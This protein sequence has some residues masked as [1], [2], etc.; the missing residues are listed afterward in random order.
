MPYF[1]KGLEISQKINL[2]YFPLSRFEIIVLE[3]SKE[4][5]TKIVNFMTPGGGVLVLRCGHISDIVKMNYFCENLLFSLTQIRQFEGIVM[6]SK[7]GS[8]KIVNFMTPRAGIL[9]LGC[10]QISCI[11]KMLYFFKNLLLFTWA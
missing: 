8:A 2:T 4:G 11:V 3:I 6:M 10:G 7:E 9:V 5:S 1:V